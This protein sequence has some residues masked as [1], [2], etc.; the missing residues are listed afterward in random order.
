M[1]GS[2]SRRMASLPLAPPTTTRKTAHLVRPYALFT[3]PKCVGGRVPRA[4][5]PAIGRTVAD[6][7]PDANN[8]GRPQERSVTLGFEESF[9]VDGR[10]A[11][12]PGCGDGL[13]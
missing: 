5:P 12:H 10:L 3:G 9:R 7:A 8:V 1:W 2:S 6:R 4:S 13:P 11:S